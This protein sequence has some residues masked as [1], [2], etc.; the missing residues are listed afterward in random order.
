MKKYGS[1]VA[2]NGIGFNEGT[3]LA[4][5]VISYKLKAYDLHNPSLI[6]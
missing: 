6:A 1:G 5:Q 2:L 3:E 4:K